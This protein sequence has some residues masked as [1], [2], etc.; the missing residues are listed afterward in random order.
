[1]RMVETLHM[2]AMIVLIAFALL[3]ACSNLLDILVG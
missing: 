3:L 2:V 1:M